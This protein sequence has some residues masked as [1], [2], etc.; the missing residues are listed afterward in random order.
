MN[1][2]KLVPIRQSKNWARFAKYADEVGI[3]LEAEEDWYSW[4]EAWMGGYNSAFAD[5]NEQ[6]E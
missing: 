4:Y 2:P 3:N 6:D 5:A 1:S